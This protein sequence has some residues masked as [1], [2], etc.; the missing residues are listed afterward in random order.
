MVRNDERE[1]PWFYMILHDAIWFYVVKGCDVTS[2]YSSNFKTFLAFSD[3]FYK[4]KNLVTKICATNV[5]FL[6][7]ENMLQNQRPVILDT[8]NWLVKSCKGIHAT[9]SKTG[10]LGH[11]GLTCETCK[12][13]HATKSKAGIWDFG[14]D[15]QPVSAF[16]LQNQRQALSDFGWGLV[17]LVKF[18]ATKSKTDTLDC[19][20]DL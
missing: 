19:W 18:H 6:F 2:A 12:Q 7:K 17:E 14:W 3:F 5:G 1:E 16:M 11:L 8:F 20:W 10:H 13:T 15:L 4:I 9:K